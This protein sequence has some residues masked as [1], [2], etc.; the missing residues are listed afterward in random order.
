LK[1][2]IFQAA[3]LTFHNDGCSMLGIVFTTS[4]EASTFAAE[5]TDGP[6]PTIEKG[7]PLTVG[8]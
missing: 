1:A 5:Y 6:P 3:Y 8:T 7:T 2:A 4:H